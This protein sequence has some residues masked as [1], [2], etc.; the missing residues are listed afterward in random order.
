MAKG[1][2]AAGW[3]SLILSVAPRRLRWLSASFLSILGWTLAATVAFAAGALAVV[4]VSL[5][6]Q[7]RPV[8]ATLGILTHLP[9]VAAAAVLAVALGFAL[10]TLFRSV[11]G[12]VLLGYVGTVSVGLLDMVRPGLSSWF[13]IN[14]AMTVLAGTSPAPHGMGPVLVAL[15][16]WVIVPAG[17]GVARLRR[18]DLR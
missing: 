9:N 2:G 12:P 5:A 1:S 4:A 7:G 6:S 13:D 10:G 11:A 14:A 16:C 8:A 15:G 17:I 18:S 3:V